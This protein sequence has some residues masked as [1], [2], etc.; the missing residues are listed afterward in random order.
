MSEH[1]D[2]MKEAVAEAK[3]GLSEG[4]IPIGSVLV[5]DGKIVGRGHNRRVQK[6]SAVLH[7]E[8]DCLENAG[9][10]SAKAYQKSTL[11]STLSPCDMCSG[12]AL[13]YRIPKIVVG[14]NRNFQGPEEY[15]KSRGVDVIIIDDDECIT[16]MEDFIK[17][18]PDLWN[19]D[20][21]E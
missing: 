4:G 19:E 11:Y 6:S 5:I 8:M 18:R 17:D 1:H 9:R 16:M 10:L 2:F 21:G 14:E 15:V 13:L 7:A 3:L 12:A 20:I